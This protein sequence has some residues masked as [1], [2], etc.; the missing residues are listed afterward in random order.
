MYSALVGCLLAEA[1]PVILRL[2]AR[3]DGPLGTAAR[4]GALAGALALH[5]ATLLSIGDRKVYNV[6]HPYTSWLPICLFICLRNATPFLRSTYAGGLALM[7]RHSLELYLL[8]FH[9]WLGAAAKTNVV[10]LPAF[11]AISAVGMSFVFAVGAGIAFSATSAA[12]LW[13]TSSYRGAVTV[14]AVSVAL[15]ALAPVL[16]GL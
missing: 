10:P 1:R 11:R 13:A 7:G 12:V 3:F 8:Q 15:L 6:Y 9:V 16:G 4:V 14:S 2:Y 5:T